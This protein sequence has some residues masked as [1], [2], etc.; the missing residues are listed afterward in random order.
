MITMTD[1]EVWADRR[2][3]CRIPVMKAP[4]TMVL[5]GPTLSAR[6]F[7]KSLQGLRIVSGHMNA[8]ELTRKSYRPNV[9]AAF[10]IV[11]R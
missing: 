1:A 10:K 11:R 2:Q 7:G 3:N 4:G 5:S 9:L 8:R 6:I